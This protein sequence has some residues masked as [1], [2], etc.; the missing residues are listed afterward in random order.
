MLPVD[1]LATSLECGMDLGSREYTAAVTI[2][3]AAR[4]NAA[5]VLTLHRIAGRS[6]QLQAAHKA[7]PDEQH[8]TSVVWS[9]IPE[10]VAAVRMQCKPLRAC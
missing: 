8:T 10:E 1:D 6:S 5:R 7:R 4:A 3:S 9:C 2:Q